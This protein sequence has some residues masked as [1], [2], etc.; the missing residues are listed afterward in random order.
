MIGRSS[1]LVLEQYS[2][3]RPP[4]IH[5]GHRNGLAGVVYATSHDDFE[6]RSNRD[7]MKEEDF[8]GERT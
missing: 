8:S 1:I 6:T 3:G 5:V 2:N 4:L 7:T